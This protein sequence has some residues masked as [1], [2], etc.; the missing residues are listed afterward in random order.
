MS[1]WRFVD[2]LSAQGR[3]PFYDWLSALPKDAQAA[4]DQRIATMASMARWPEKWVSDYTGADGLIEFRISWNRVQYRPLG[5][6][7]KGHTFVLLCGAIEQNWKI[8][9]R[10]I[11]TALRRRAELLVEPDRVEPHRFSA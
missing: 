6:Y 11:N 7:A 1:V 9:R 10:H 5:T 8:P 2:F 4:I 3:N